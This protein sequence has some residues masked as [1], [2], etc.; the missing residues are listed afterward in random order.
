[1]KG[2]G[3]MEEYLLNKEYSLV[4][5]ILDYLS[6]E[7][8][9]GIKISSLAEKVKVSRNTLINILNDF[10]GDCVLNGWL[11]DVVLMIEH[12]SIVG[13]FQ[14]SFHLNRIY[15]YYL[16]KSLGFRILE[17]LLYENFETIPFMADEFDV[18]VATLSRKLNE[19]RE[20]LKTYKITL[21]LKNKNVLIGKES[22]IRFF[23]F[24]LY[25]QVFEVGDWE[26]PEVDESEIDNRIK[27]LEKA[28]SY[29]D[30]VVMMKF[31]IML[32]I[33]KIRLLRGHFIDS[34]KEEFMIDEHPMVP[35]EVFKE[36]FYFSLMNVSSTLEMEHR[37]HY[38]AFCSINSFTIEESQYPNWLMKSAKVGFCPYTIE[39]I[40]VFTD[41]FNV[42]LTPLEYNYLLVNLYYYHKFSE[43]F[44]G[45]A[46]HFGRGG[47][48][49][50]F[51]CEHSE[52]YN[53]Y[54]GFLSQLMGSGQYQ[55]YDLW[56][57]NPRLTQEYCL[58]VKTIL[59]NHQPIVK[60]LIYSKVSKIK[61]QDIQDMI[62]SRLSVNVQF[63]ETIAEHPSAIISD[64]PVNTRYIT[65]CP[66]FQFR[67]FQREED[68]INLQTFLINLIENS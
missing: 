51:S 46:I 56:Q 11:E 25:W 26:F 66:V 67:P 32:A 19:L 47:Q 55:F 45:G 68:W 39:W 3:V 58:L 61:K 20:L 37:F 48:A 52:D 43:K 24:N 22:Q 14:P 13:H 65:S 7:G 28:T 41:Y 30:G 44:A 17:H 62:R 2:T 64:F 35:Y 33:S 18:S 49:D 36:T 60:L 9:K 4:L 10:Q 21:N 5:E 15:K 27:I 29:F 54:V 6:I 53:K 12:S 34:E 23:Y 59:K 40:R 38:F 16:E 8:E 31:K 1:M 57:N 42:Q 63:V 50:I